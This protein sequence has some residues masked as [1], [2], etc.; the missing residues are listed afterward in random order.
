MRASPIYYIEPSAISITPNCN[1]SANDLAI[2]VAPNSRIKV[3]SKNS[4]IDTANASFQEWTISGRNRRLSQ[5]DVE[6]TIYARLPKND[7]AGGYLV[8]APKWQYE[9]EWVDKYPYV[10]EDGIEYPRAYTLPGDNWYIRLGD[11]SLPEDGN[12]TVTFDTGILGTD[13]YN[14]E[15][16][17]NSDGLPFRIDLSCKIGDADAGQTPYVKW[18]ELITIDAL[19]I[20][21]WETDATPQ[22]GYWTISRN[23]GNADSDNE[24]NH[25]DGTNRFRRMADGHVSLTHS[26]DTDDDFNGAVA[27]TYTISAY[28][29]EGEIIGSNTIT[30]LAETVSIYE[31]EVSSDTVSYNRDKKNYIPSEDISI[32]IRSKSQNGDVSYINQARIETEQLRVYCL[33]KET[34]EGNVGELAFSEGKAFLSVTTVKEGK[35]VIL[36]LKNRDNN[37]LSQITISYVYIEG[38]LSTEEDDVAR[39]VITFLKGALFGATGAWGWVKETWTRTVDGMEETLEGG[40]AWFKTLLA[41]ALEVAGKTK[42]A[43]LEVADRVLGPLKVDGSVFIRKDEDGK[44][45]DLSVAGDATIGGKATMGN[46]EVRN[47]LTTKN[48]TVTGLAHFFELVIDKLRSAGGAMVYTP[49]DGFEVEVVQVR[50]LAG[51]IV[52]RRLLW[53]ATDGEKKSRN[54]W[55]ALDQALCMNFNAVDGSSSTYTDTSNKQFWAVVESAGTLRNYQPDADH[56]LTDWHYIDIY[57]GEDASTTPA[58][59]AN[60]ERKRPLW[61]GAAYSVEPGD[62]VAMLGY[63]GT[64]DKAR[65]SAIYV[66]AYASYDSGLT[67]PLLAFYRGADD[68]D[69]ASHRTTYMDANGSVFKGQ[70]LSTSSSQDGIDIESLL[71]GSEFDIIYGDGNPNTVTKPH[72]TLW[73]ESE[74]LLHVG[75]LYFDI[76]LEPASEGGRLWRWQ[77]VGEDAT[78]SFKGYAWVSVN[79][80]DSLAALDKIAD[81]ASDG[82]LSGGAEKV[83]VYLEW[84]EARKTTV[85]LLAQAAENGAGDSN[86]ANWNYAYKDKGQST[87]ATC[88]EAYGDLEDSFIMLSRYL[89]N[90]SSGWTINSNAV[91]AFIDSSDSAIGMGVTT[92]LPTWAEVSGYANSKGAEI[93]RDLW[94][95]FY[96][97]VVELTRALNAAQYKAIDEMGDDGLLDPAEKAVLR[98]IFS[99]E[100]TGYY[101]IVEE[102]DAVAGKVPS[103]LANA[104]W[105]AESS[106]MTAINELGSYMHGASVAD[107]GNGGWHTLGVGN[108]PGYTWFITDSGDHRFDSGLVDPPETGT[109][110]LNVYPLWL[111]R[112][113]ETQVVIDEQWDYFWKRLSDAR[114]ALQDTITNG[115]QYQIENV[116]TQ[117]T[118]YTRFSDAGATAASAVKG[119]ENL[120]PRLMPSGTAIKAGDRWYEETVLV[121]P[122]TKELVEKDSNN[123]PYYNMYVCTSAYGTSDNVTYA[124][125]FS[126]WQQVFSPVA[127]V[128]SSGVDGIYDAVFASDRFTSVEQT[129]DSI[130]QTV[131]RM[132]KKNML[133]NSDFADG[134][135]SHF[136]Y[137]GSMPSRVMLSSGLPDGFS[138]GAS[139]SSNSGTNKYISM[140]PGIGDTLQPYMEIEYNKTYT[141]SFW[142]KS[143]S[144][145]TIRIVHKSATTSGWNAATGSVVVND[146][147]LISVWVRYIFTFVGITPSAPSL[148]IGLPSTGNFQMTGL[149]L[150]EGGTASDWHAYGTSIGEMQSQIKQNT[151]N[152]SLTVTKD[153]ARKAGIDIEYDDSSD[154]GSV[155][156]MG[157]Q[158]TI[159]GDL[160][161]KGLTTENVTIVER[162]PVRPTVVNMGIVG[163]SDAAAVKVKSVQVRAMNE[164]AYAD[165]DGWGS[166]DGQHMVV[167]PF[168]DSLVGQSGQTLWPNLSGEPISFETS[169]KTAA[170]YR[171]FMLWGDSKVDASQRRVVTWRQ[172]GTRLTVTNES[173]V[174]ARN[175]ARTAT[176]YTYRTNAS[177]WLLRRSVVVCADARIVC[178]ANLQSDKPYIATFQ[179][180]NA[181]TGSVTAAGN[182]SK[183]RGGLL[184]CGGYM[185]RFLVLL[186]GQSV[187]LRS[188]IMKIDSTR[189]VLT[190]VVENPS[191]FEP[192]D[193][194]VLRLNGNTTDD[195]STLLVA[196]NVAFDPTNSEEA[197]MDTVLGSKVA[198]YYVHQDYG[199]VGFDFSY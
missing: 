48:L 12:R 71:S 174:Y 193:G 70:F 34:N 92:E 50:A 96:N 184:S 181:G 79:D 199:S 45:G 68:F 160:D 91:P 153:G 172:N 178:A 30:I 148:Y 58:V 117:A 103:G 75:T 188:Q 29:L 137:A 168:Y 66:S 1:S 80:V 86:G 145:S 139:V 142:A 136:G 16:N 115:R 198:G 22:V 163:A 17:L 95:N 149:Q 179:S 105:N 97:A 26:H 72:Q 42:T 144:S 87:E 7:K 114:L 37:I 46:A 185:S 35:G 158:V 155:T 151:D 171:S 132:V 94:N 124:N 165:A 13:L 90:K 65:Q 100:V 152:I 121:N 9:E 14:T 36:Q 106:Y 125:R 25:P 93:Y 33:S 134:Y 69:L 62:E 130:T 111:Q 88:G 76:S 123:Q 89:N 108:Q 101:K 98:Q 41:D 24:W 196:Q 195:K 23:T 21:G 128:R 53:R 122:V 104:I 3:Y 38:G 15:W 5:S 131:S 52:G 59:D 39:G 49:A 159:D 141:F 194:F 162:T 57:T 118:Y 154:K 40:V 167:L 83:R 11:V 82:I 32:R 190:W 170:T 74:Y 10:T 28:S 77:Q 129:A 81:V 8:F 63:R 127:V 126:R 102:G 56:E 191:E 161:V 19:L 44:G 146:I 166:N 84:M 138:S 99:D 143:N 147:G 186:P 156:L 112:P 47:T 85:S 183:G 67:P 6:Y 182:D 120:T 177:K 51:G 150:E 73:K 110:P 189:E 164:A 169:D 175:W 64:D 113:D 116:E 157:D 18:G 180:G 187:Q 135:T 107:D 78:V 54:M 176:T 31:L 55:K 173:D 20:K 133:L 197:V 43:V 192:L 60:D 4:G 27:A 119:S 140:I 109:A 2:Y 61:E